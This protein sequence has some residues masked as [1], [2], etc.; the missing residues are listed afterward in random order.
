MPELRHLRV[1][2]AVAEQLSFTR[3]AERLHMTQQSVSRTVGEL[4]RE[5]GVT[6][7]ERTTREVR[8]TAAGTALL[9]DGS[10][11]L[12]VAE[13]AFA[14]AR[15]VGTGE[16]G[17]VR[18]GFSPAI[19]PLD[20]DDVV[21]ALRP[22]GSSVSVA[23]HEVRPGELRRLLRANELDVALT[24]A[25]GERDD[26]LHSVRLRPTPMVLCVPAGHRLAARSSV[27]LADLD[28][29]RL[30]VASARG[31]AYTDLLV[32]AIEAAG[33]AVSIV[34]ARVTGGATL[35]T[36]FNDDDVVA[37]MPA[38]TSP[39]AGITVVDVDD[40]TVPMVL[41]WPAGR[42]SA[43]VERLRRALER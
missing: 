25:S 37:L 26:A 22:P 34:E 17:R 13:A 15:E 32:D 39:R 8:L 14:R 18:V 19:G 23:L 1:F 43:A 42:P 24:R 11:A 3:A 6:L 10:E 4:E 40:F 16:L 12:R 20:R 31:S 29:E 2:A 35:L 9:A 36:E 38:G 7:L 28:G 27:A 5:L 21:R 33:A 30:L 41:L